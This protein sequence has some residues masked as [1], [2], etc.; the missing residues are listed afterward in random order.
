M[1]RNA[2]LLSQYIEEM[3]GMHL[4]VRPTTTVKDRASHISLL[5]DPKM[6]NDEAY[7]IVVTPKGVEISG[8]TPAG[9]FYGMQVLRQSLPVGEATSVN[10]PATQVSSSPRRTAVHGVAKSRTRLSD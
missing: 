3:T 8:K 6:D 7:S 4:S 10:L 5:L 1:E 9:V 2:E